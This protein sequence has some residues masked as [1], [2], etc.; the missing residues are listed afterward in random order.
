MPLGQLPAPLQGA[1]APLCRLLVIG[2]YQLLE[3]LVDY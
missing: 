1:C 3:L 2:R